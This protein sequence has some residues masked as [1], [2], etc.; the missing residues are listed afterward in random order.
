MVRGQVFSAAPVHA[1]RGELAGLD[2]KAISAAASAERGLAQEAAESAR[3]HGRAA[4]RDLAEYCAQWRIDNPLGRGDGAR[5]PARPWAMP[6]SGASMTR[7]R[8]TSCAATVPRRSG[9]RTRCAG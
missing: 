8:A 2:A 1:I 7:S 3:S 4:E 9:P 5:R 6:G